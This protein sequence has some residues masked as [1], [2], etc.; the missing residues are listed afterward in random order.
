MSYK[1]VY[2]PEVKS[3]IQD[4][5]IWYNEQQPGLGQYFYK[6]I[7]EH[8]FILKQSPFLFSIRYDDIRCLPTKVFPY[9]IH[10]R[11]HNN[12]RTVSVEAIMHTSRHPRK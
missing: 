2:N 3:D 7:K 5:V 9:M 10:Y 1:I 6:V 12:D 11:V 8:I 4:A